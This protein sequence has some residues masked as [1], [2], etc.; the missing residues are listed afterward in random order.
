[1]AFIPF[2]GGLALVPCS[3]RARMLTPAAAA[4]AV[5]ETAVAQ[6]PAPAA[7]LRPLEWTVVQLARGDRLWSLARPG[8]LVSALRAAF[9]LH[10]PRLADPRLEAL[11]RI[12]VLTWHYGFT[13]PSAE[14][15]AFLAAGF[16]TE[17]YE[18]MVDRIGSIQAHR[19][20]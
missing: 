8:R 20:R 9:R 6:A 17:Q 13:V 14:V 19:P 4:A 5:A 2:D 12:A 3:G 15:Q 11:R 7:A 1:M 18:A 16:S 10:N